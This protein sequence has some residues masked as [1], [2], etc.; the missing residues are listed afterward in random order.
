MSMS[1]RLFAL[2]L[3]AGLLASTAAAQDAAT[4]FGS[5]RGEIVDEATGE[6]IPS[7][8]VALLSTPDSSLVTG[9]ITSGD[10]A[11]YIENIRPGDY[12]LRAS[13]VGYD[14]EII[15]DVNISR[16]EPELSLGR[17][18]LSAATTAL[19][20]VE[21]AADRVY[22]QFD[23][24][25]TVYNIENQPL[26]AGGSAR[27]ALEQLPSVNIDFD[28]SISLRG[29]EN[30]VIYLNG[31]PS[32]MSGDALIGFL[33][34]LPSSAVDRIEVIPNPS[35]AFEPE[36][37][38]GIINIVL[39]EDEEIGLGGGL[40]ASINTRNSYR[41][42]G[43][44]RY[45][46]GPWN[47]YTNYGVRYG[48]R[49]S[50]GY[51]FREN[52]YLDP[53]TYLE[54]NEISERGGLSQYFNTT[55]GYR[56]SEMNTLSLS[57]RA[58]YRNSD[59]DERRLYN[60]LDADREIIDVFNRI[61]DGEGSEV[62][63]DVRLS[64]QRIVEPQTHELEVEANFEYEQGSDLER[65]TQRSG[66]F[67]AEGDIFEQQNVEEGEREME[68]ELEADYERPL[69]EN[70]SLEAGYQSA[71]EREDN[72]LFSETYN[73]ATGAFEPDNNLNSIF[74]YDE[75]IHS[76]YG[77]F[78]GNLGD[79]GAQLGGR[80]ER[81]NTTFDI[82]AGDEPFINSYF[83]FF[84]SVHLSFRPVQSHL[85]RTSYSKRVNRPNTW[86]LNPFGDFDDP[87]SRRIGNP[88]L[89]PEYTHSFEVGYT[90][91]GSGYTLSVAPYY[92]HTVNAITWDE[93]LTDE[94]VTLVTFE[95]FAT[96]NSSGLE[97]AGSVSPLDWLDM[98]LSFNAYRRITDGSNVRDDLGS[99]AYGY[100]S[101]LS[102]TA[103]IREGLALQFSQYYRSPIDVPNG[104]MDAFNSTSL[105]L[106]HQFMDDRASLSLSA[107][108]IFNTMNFSMWRE[109]PQYYEESIHDWGARSVRLSFRYT[110]GEQDD[111]RREQQEGGGGETEGGMPGMGM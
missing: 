50:S 81:A 1:S 42:S 33:N 65:Y 98:R 93:R 108:D 64:F 40:S 44:V 91:L 25:R 88:D 3:F 73:P 60:V 80:L 20:G 22:M 10:G 53:L 15:A 62:S 32:P 26:T 66:E 86:Q 9:G 43:N 97:L 110:F 89:D 87:T 17:I 27:D 18:A 31:Q 105:S 36:G 104:H 57:G 34:S 111:R 13:F 23:V 103:E 69:G 92:R 46:A 38:A 84:P 94:G 19:E 74:V 100:R 6:P 83:S 82:E 51:Q 35:A 39:A 41:A 67:D 78:S 8:T 90:N 107:R 76:L 109:T 106:R 14:S 48:R 29:N 72:E 95:N 61:T 16:A 49:E 45:G 52:R 37:L 77:V 7:A 68:L 24:D 54:Q 70:A 4:S 75:I 102:A 2:L 56:L 12:L 28:G 11:F 63:T 85:F 21:V 79:F 71:W 99:D 59:G 96:R 58:R 47:V 55:V 101:R 30:V 5:I